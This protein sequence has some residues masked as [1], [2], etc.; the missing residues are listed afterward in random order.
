MNTGK[1]ITQNNNHNECT[2]EQL[3]RIFISGHELKQ[4]R[5]KLSAITQSVYKVIKDSTAYLTEIKEAPRHSIHQT[6]RKSIKNFDNFLKR[7]VEIRQ[8]IIDETNI[9]VLKV[10]SQICYLYWLNSIEYI[11]DARTLIKK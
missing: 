1:T 7:I 9:D 8:E 2:L 4:D 6:L 3:V 5:N 11:N 10:V